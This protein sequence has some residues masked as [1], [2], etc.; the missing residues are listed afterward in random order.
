MNS[1]SGDLAE[2]A[3]AAASFNRQRVERK[4]V[5]IVRSAGRSWSSRARRGGAGAATNTGRPF[6]LRAKLMCAIQITAWTI[7]QVP[8]PRLGRLGA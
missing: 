2:H 4:A 6:T 3:A 7:A 5:G 1:T 8:Y